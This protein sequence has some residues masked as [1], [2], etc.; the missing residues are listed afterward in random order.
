M[1]TC[2]QCR[3]CEPACPSGVPF[4]RLIE[5][6][7]SELAPQRTHHSA[8]AALG[9]LD[10]LRHTR[11]CSPGST[12]LAVAQR[13]RLVP[14]RLGLA[15]LPLRR[16]A[17]G[18]APTGA[19]VW[20]FTGCVMDAWMRATHR[21]TAA[22]STRWRQLCRAGRGRVRAAARCTLTPDSTTRRSSWRGGHGVDARRRPD[23]RQLGRV[24]R[25]AEGLRPP[26]RHRR[27]TAVLGA[28][29]R[30]PRVDR[31]ARRSPA[32]AAPLAENRSSCKTRATCAT[33]S[34]RTCPVRAWSG[35]SPTLVELDDDGLCCGAGGAYSALAARARRR[36]SATQAGR[37]RPCDRVVGCDGGSS[38][39]TRAA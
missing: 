5:A 39:R 31:R 37:D 28:G 19:D 21:S 27:G 7:R 8:L 9:V 15:R 36:R 34:R 26:A 3:G 29:A 14:R 35:A 4:G 12:V 24:W 22:C 25:S 23:P 38:V 11:R 20:L 13:L 18:H 10:V 32:R 16:G 1:T 33:C 17:G 6:T 30:R 2:V